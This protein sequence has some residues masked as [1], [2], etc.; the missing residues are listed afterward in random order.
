MRKY[1]SDK[2]NINSKR[3]DMDE[4]ERR[5]EFTLTV[6]LDEQKDNNQNWIPLHQCLL[7]L[8]DSPLNHKGY[9]E[10]FIRLLDRRIVKLHRE[11]R[12]P[13]TFKR[14]EQLF[15]NFLQGCDMPLVQTKDGQTRLLQFVNKTTFDK[16]LQLSN[17]GDKNRRNS[18]GSSIYKRFRV[19]NLAPKLKSADYFTSSINSNCER[20]TLFVEFG[21][22]DFNILGDG[23]EEEYE[24]KTIKNESEEIE[25]YTYSISRYPISPAL[26]CVKLLT[27][28]ESALDVF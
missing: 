9:L 4:K 27:S 22:V 6:V 1:I 23:R 7:M 10:V 28:F 17:N 8:F 3:L 25:D 18:S 20:I 21:P 5:Q 16:K 11:V 24:M 12:I 15:N 13:R 2:D 26:T 19:C 14:F